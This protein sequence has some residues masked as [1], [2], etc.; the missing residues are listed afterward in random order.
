M[1]VFLLPCGVFAQSDL[2]VAID[3]KPGS[4]PNP[5]NIKSR[6]VLTVAILGTAD[7]DVSTID[8]VSIRLY[9]N[10]TEVAAPIRSRIEDVATPF[11]GDILSCNDCYISG[12]DGYQDLTVKFRTQDIVAGLSS[13]IEAETIIDGDCIGLQLKGSAD[14]DDTTINFL[15]EDAVQILIKGKTPNRYFNG[16]RNLH[17]H[18]PTE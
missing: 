14:I 13:D 11:I 7:F 3:I 1:F 15:G 18:F 4:C 12:P 6:G 10:G 17:R 5:L 9:Y 16:N 8:P 2:P